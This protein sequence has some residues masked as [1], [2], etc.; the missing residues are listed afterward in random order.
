MSR[1][2]NYNLYCVGA[3]KENMG[4]FLLHLLIESFSQ[5]SQDKTRTK[6]RQ[7]AHGQWNVARV[8]NSLNFP[9]LV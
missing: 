6:R 9:L 7:I 2:I 5:L 1:L 4:P 8:S 3:V